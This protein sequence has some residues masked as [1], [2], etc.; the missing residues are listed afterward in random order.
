MCGLAFEFAVVDDAE[1]IVGFIRIDF[2]GRTSRGGEGSGD[3]ESGGGDGASL[4]F[5]GR[6]WQLHVHVGT[7]ELPGVVEVES[8]DISLLSAAGVTRVTTPGIDAAKPTVGAAT[9]LVDRFLPVVPSLVI[10]TS[11]GTTF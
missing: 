7:R 6:K 11:S 4:R 10:S 1:L 2:S 5:V 8:G 3:A 9:K